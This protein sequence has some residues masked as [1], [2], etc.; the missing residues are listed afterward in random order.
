MSLMTRCVLVRLRS[1]TRA[2]TGWPMP[3][4]CQVRRRAALAYCREGALS[5]TD[6]LD[7]WRLPGAPSSRVHVTVGP[8]AAQLSRGL[9]LH[10]RLDH[11]PEPPMVVV[12][13]GLRVVRLESAVV[14]SWSLL[15]RLQRRAPAIVAVRERRTTPARLLEALDSRPQT[16]GA[17]DQRR[18][19]TL[20]AAGNHS[21]LEIWGHHNVFTD[22]ALPP[23]VAQHRV[24]IGGQVF[25]FDRAFLEEMVAVELDGAAYHGSPGQ[26]ERDLRRDAITAQGGWLTVRYSHPRLHAQPAEVVDELAAIL[27]RRREQL[28]LSA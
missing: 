4:T 14:D 8:H 24:V 19:F 16:I 13:D 21:E 27:A 22:Q 18:L 12:R 20:L 5:H 25:I 3:M 11:R 15:P 6:A 26:R 9:H 1:R 23:S 28:R 10:R 17:R 7:V 2:C